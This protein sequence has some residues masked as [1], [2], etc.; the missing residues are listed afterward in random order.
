MYSN[1]KENSI[2]LSLSYSKAPT[3]MVMG[4]WHGFVKARQVVKSAQVAKSSGTEMMKLV[5]LFPRMR[6]VF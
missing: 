2:F 5:E 4:P 3:P 1:L 6:E